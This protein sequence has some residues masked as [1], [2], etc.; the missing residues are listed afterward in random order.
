M[1]GKSK[2]S[3]WGRLTGRKFKDKGNSEEG[4]GT[5]VTRSSATGR[6]AEETNALYASATTAP[7]ASDTP[8]RNIPHVAPNNPESPNASLDGDGS[9]KGP[10]GC[11]KEPTTQSTLTVPV[12]AHE[13]KDEVANRAR[14]P[15][16]TVED[17][18]KPSADHAEGKQDGPGLDS[19]S[20][21]TLH[22]KLWD[23]AYDSLEREEDEIVK[24]YVKTLTKVLLTDANN[25]SATLATDIQ[26]SLKDRTARQEYLQQLVN[27]GKQKV[28]KS[29]K[30]SKAIGDFADT[31]LQLKPLVDFAVTVP[32]A[33]PAALPWAGVCV[34]LLVS[35]CYVSTPSCTS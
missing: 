27:N 18:L 21:A 35:R 7:E 34:G 28:E 31:I 23:D 2:S 32:H 24:A 10:P 12:N 15:T 8:A 33:A 9:M 30:I 29:T 3:W 13:I 5:E 6:L 11:G 14:L 1:P 4:N 26:I 22:R 25:T 16:P 19:V 20:K 17:G